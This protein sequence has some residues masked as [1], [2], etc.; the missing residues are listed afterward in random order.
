MRITSSRMDITARIIDFGDRIIQLSQVVSVCI[1]TVHPL[2][3]FARWPALLAGALGL[4]EV[5]RFFT[6]L[7]GPAA[8]ILSG[9][10]AMALI[11]ATVATALYLYSVRLL[12]I[13]TSDGMPAWIRTKDLTF[14]QLVL[15][16][17]RLALTTHDANF[18]VSIDLDARTID[19]D[20]SDIGTAPPSFGALRAVPEPDSRAWTMPSETAPALAALA[21]LPEHDVAPIA[22]GA[23]RST[24]KSAFAEALQREVGPTARPSTNGK[25]EVEEIIQLIAAASIPHKSE[26][27]ALLAP[28]RDHV[29]GGRTNRT[30]ARRNWQLFHDY[31]REYLS[32]VDGLAECCGRVETV[33]N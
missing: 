18:R 1:G 14:L 29:A 12:I 9:I 7:G 21:T 23:P 33:L 4:L 24:P 5:A 28:V 20:D 15:E 30:D 32:D 26:L 3:P 22:N 11:S 25:T 17:I 10:S 13:S 16:K 8:Q 19:A 2:R 31:A 27:N 6:E